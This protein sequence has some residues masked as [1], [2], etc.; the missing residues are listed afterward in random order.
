MQVDSERRATIKRFTPLRRARYLEVLAQTGNLRAAAE[1]IGFRRGRLAGLC[2]RDPD[3]A[4]QCDTAR[5]TASARLEGAEGPFEGVEDANFETLRRGR[6]G[7]VSIIAVG[8]GRWSK[9]IEDAFI[10][11]LASTGNIERSAQAVGFAGTDM[12]RRRRQW[13]AF[14]R[15]WDEALEEAETRL[16]FRLVN[17][18]NSSDPD[19][20]STSTASIREEAFDREF[21]LKFL[22]WREEKRRGGGA[23]GRVAAP[24]TIAA[25]TERIIAKVAAIQRHD[26]AAQADLNHAAADQPMSPEAT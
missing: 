3:F 16:E 5:D 15:R 18:G 26:D 13:P 22:K 20:D 2:K 21:A 23:R 24:P 25:V 14:A 19:P 6:D 11:R 12:F 7:R 4:A 9:Q 10:A 1:A 17:W 8:P